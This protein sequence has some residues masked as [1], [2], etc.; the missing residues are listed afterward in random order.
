VADH[1]QTRRRLLRLRWNGAIRGPGSRATFAVS[2][3]LLLATA[4]GDK[5]IDEAVSVERTGSSIA[6]PLTDGQASVDAC[7]EF[8]SHFAGQV[9]VLRGAFRSDVATVS[10]WKSGGRFPEAVPQFLQGR[11]ANE[12]IY[13]CFFDMDIA[14]PCHPGSPGSNRGLY[15]L[16]S[17]GAGA[18]LTAGQHDMPGVADLPVVAPG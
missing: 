12:L 6:P 2:L 4:C 1:S 3:L 15:L 16:D 7:T 9:A 17:S 10:G 14:A 5:P 8:A 11:L 18:L 13:A